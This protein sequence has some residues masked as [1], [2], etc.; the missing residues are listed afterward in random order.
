MKVLFWFRENQTDKTK[1]GVIMATIQV[2]NTDGQTASSDFATTCKVFRRDYHDGKHERD[3]RAI[4]LELEAVQIFLSGQLNRETTAAEIK[5]EYLRRKPRKTQT[6][7]KPIA[8]NT[9]PTPPT[10]PTVQE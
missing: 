10:T 7:P 3:K 6:K 1:K 5:A 4:Q 2:A 9:P 8:E